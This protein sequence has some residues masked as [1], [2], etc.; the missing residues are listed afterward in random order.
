MLLV[1]RTV[2]T[3]PFS[4]PSGWYDTSSGYEN[5]DKCAYNYGSVVSNSYNVALSTGNFLCVAQPG[6]R[7]S[8]TRGAN[9]A[10]RPTESNKTGTPSKALALSPREQATGLGARPLNMV[11]YRTF[12]S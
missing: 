3:D 11:Y 6:V 5:G 1:P 12:F 10:I 7:L 4:N 9:H 2:A 8:Q